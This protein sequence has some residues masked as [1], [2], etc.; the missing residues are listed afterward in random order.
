MVFTSVTIKRV[1][2][3][4]RQ[5]HARTHRQ[6]P[7][8]VIPMCR[9]ASQA[10]QGDTKRKISILIKITPRALFVWRSSFVMWPVNS[11]LLNSQ[12]F[13]F[14]LPAYPKVAKWSYNS[15][16]CVILIHIDHLV[17]QTTIDRSTEHCHATIDVMERQISR[18]KRQASAYCCQY[19]SGL[20]QL[21]NKTVISMLLLEQSIFC[22]SVVEKI[23]E[24]CCQRPLAIVFQIF[25]T[26]SGQ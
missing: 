14:L 16:K 11:A 7:D 15:Q 20:K 26:T 5:M 13:V 12:Y 24:N 2:L 23:W 17:I 18:L 1:W 19:F 21:G 9:Y 6:T 25:S 3:S 4:D 10:T 22:P 8:K